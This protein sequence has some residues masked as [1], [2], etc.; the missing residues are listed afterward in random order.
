MIIIKLFIPLNALLIIITLCNMHLFWKSVSGF[1]FVCPLEKMDTSLQCC[2]M[3]G[4]NENSL[5]ECQY[6]T[7]ERPGTVPI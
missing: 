2:G 1:W 3:S 7:S 6:I 5:I 4:G